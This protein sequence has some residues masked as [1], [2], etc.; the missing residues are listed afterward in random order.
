MVIVVGMISFALYYF[1]FTFLIRKLDIE[2]PGRE[3]GATVATE[4]FKTEDERAIKTLEYLGGKEN[5]IDL[6][7]CITR[8]R[9]VVDDMDRINVD[10]LKGIGMREV[11][12]LT[13]G[14]VQVIVGLEV[15]QLAPKIKTLLT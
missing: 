3:K 15:E 1:S 9:L 6:D 4:E 11:I 5:I 14:K 7:N 2:T 12:K 8:L 13:N 10:K